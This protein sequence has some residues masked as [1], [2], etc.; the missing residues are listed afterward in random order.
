[1]HSRSVLTSHHP[2]YAIG[3]LTKRAVS[4]GYLEGLFSPY[5]GWFPGPASFRFCWLLFSRLGH[6]V[7]SC[8]ILRD[9]G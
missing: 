6:E 5:S 1:M 7:A 4:V 2:L 9:Q 8:H 3:V